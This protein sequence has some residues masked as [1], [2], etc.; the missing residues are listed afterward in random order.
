MK[1]LVK[2][3][4]EL[5]NNFINKLREV[6]ITI[7]AF[8][9]AIKNIFKKSKEESEF[10]GLNPIENADQDGV[11]SKALK[12]AMD[13]PKITNIAVS[14]IYSAGKSSVIRTFFHKPD[15][16]KYNPIYISLMP[17]SENKNNEESGDNNEMCRNIEKSILQQIFYTEKRSKVKLSRFNRLNKESKLLNILISIGIW[18]V[19]YV[20]LQLCLNVWLDERIALCKLLIENYGLPFKIVLGVAAVFIFLVT[21]KCVFLLFNRTNIKKGKVKNFEIEIGDKEESIFNKYLDEI[22]YYFQVTHHRAV[23]IEDLDRYELNAIPIFQKLRELNILINESKNVPYEVNF[24]YAIGDDFLK[25]PKHRIK[26]FD[27][28]IPI[29]P[30][31]S[32]VYSKEVIWNRL[33]ELKNK[34]YLEHKLEKNFI[35]KIA[36]YVGDKRL[37]DNIINEFIIYKRKLNLKNLDDKK[38]FSIITYKNLYPAKYS[39][40][41][42]G[43]GRIVEIFG[44]KD[45]IKNEIINKQREEISYKKEKLSDAEKDV[46]NNI[47]I[48]KYALVEH[49]RGLCR[50]NNVNF[51]IGSKSVTVTDII[52]KDKDFFQ[53]NTIQIGANYGAF[54]RI[55]EEQIFSIF[56]SKENFIRKWEAIENESD[57]KKSLIK[58][59]IGDIELKISEIENLDLMQ[60]C[61]QYDCNDLFKDDDEEQVFIKNGFIAED[62]KDYITCFVEGDISKSDCEFILSVNNNKAQPYNYKLD[63]VDKIVESFESVDYNKQAIINLDLMDYLVS[64]GEDSK[65]KNI[66]E[67]LD[68]QD[69]FVDFVDDYMNKFESKNKFSQLL[70]VHS[71]TLWNRIYDSYKVNKNIEKLNFWISLY[72][73]NEE[74][75]ANLG[76]SFKNC[77]ENYEN[78]DSIISNP[79]PKIEIESLKSIGARFKN[80]NKMSNKAFLN[81]VYK[82]NMYELNTTMIHTMI[83]LLGK[84]VEN[85]TGTEIPMR[86]YEK[87]EYIGKELSVIHDD[88]KFY[89]L[90]GY[91]LDNF[92]EY[93][94]LAFSDGELKNDNEDTLKDIL[95]IEKINIDMKKRIIDLEAF[96]EYYIPDYCNNDIIEYMIEKDKVSVNYENILYKFEADGNTVCDKLANHISKHIMEYSKLNTDKV[97]NADRMDNFKNE[98]A[99]SNKVKFSDLKI[100]V[101]SWNFQ[102]SE[103]RDCESE[104]IK[105]L[106]DENLVTFNEFNY[107]YIKDN[108][109]DELFAFIKN[110]SS[111]FFENIDAYELPKETANR[112]ILDDDIGDDERAK[113]I[114]HLGGI[115]CV[116][117]SIL[118][119]M[120]IMDKLPEKYSSENDKIYTLVLEDESIIFDNKLDFLEQILTNKFNKREEYLK[121]IQCLGGEYK[122]IKIGSQ[123]AYLKI[124]DQNKRLCDILKSKLMISSYD[125]TSKK[126]YYIVRNYRK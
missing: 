47:N 115:V 65:V 34:G 49:A 107:N 52:S 67:S 56:G 33:E 16:V 93:Y 89:D 35:N 120:I 122:D 6:G 25:S 121:Y 20:M 95:N 42:K 100:I 101:R 7:V 23:I 36:V 5:S 82:N 91:L 102:I 84:N 111:N 15:N 62:F 72:L 44:K 81:Q 22:I 58:N 40:L 103:L 97:D 43:K 61:E 19:I 45:S 68:K 12:F 78:F 32:Y 123:N 27:I 74:A 71:K 106:V 18:I 9:R 108:A 31:V 87:E 29:I 17:F 116:D 117:N 104:R 105:F 76:K 69:F 48:L 54:S 88:E 39:E 83:N 125:V 64:M 70:V 109:S 66:I 80:I 112:I 90:Y 98:Y 113:I 60:L 118:L 21:Y 99:L 77:I 55:S 51:Y 126:D 24:I 26:F 114:E 63:K 1:K 124:N 10:I 4:V 79:N 13:N 8:F 92:E 37:I 2:K 59:E 46:F 38:L 41:L 119:R 14:S 110:N 53:N 50:E 75:V 96:N 28:L 85:H 57:E 73:Q 94:E 11:Y 86:H 30:V 3:A